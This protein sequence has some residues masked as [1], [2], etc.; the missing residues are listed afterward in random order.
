MSAKTKDKGTPIGSTGTI[1]MVNGPVTSTYHDVR[2]DSRGISWLDLDGQWKPLS[3]HLWNKII[4]DK[5]L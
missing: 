5:T 3:L 4:W 2:R 1:S